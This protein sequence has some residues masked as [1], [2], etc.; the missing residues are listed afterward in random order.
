[1]TTSLKKLYFKK[2]TSGQ[3]LQGLEQVLNSVNSMIVFIM[4]C[5]H[6][7]VCIQIMESDH[8]PVLVGDHC[9][10]YDCSHHS[11]HLPV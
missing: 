7:S 2:N 5:Y 10:L 9:L 11:V 3:K 8:V 6:V 4:F 1:M